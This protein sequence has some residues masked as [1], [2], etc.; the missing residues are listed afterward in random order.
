MILYMRGYLDERNVAVEYLKPRLY[1]SAVIIYEPLVAYDMLRTQRFYIDL[2]I[3]RTL[4]R[5]IVVA[6]FVAVFFLIS[7]LAELILSAA[8]GNLFGLLCTSALVFFLDPIQ[9]AARRLE[10]D[11]LAN[12]SDQLRRQRPG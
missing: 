5:T 9:K 11:T 4:K 7:G 8:L 1:V 6:L 2:R 12:A 10:D 3:K